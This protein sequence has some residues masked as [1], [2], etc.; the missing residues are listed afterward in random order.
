[1][2]PEASTRCTRQAAAA[3]APPQGHAAS[4]SVCLSCWR[5]VLTAAGLIGK[6]LAVAR[7]PCVPRL[8]INLIIDGLNLAI[9]PRA[10]VSSPN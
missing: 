2:R 3:R 10:T 4:E 6:V 5:E 1:M 7:G 9:G 8:T